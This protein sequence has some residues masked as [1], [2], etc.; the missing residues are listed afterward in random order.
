MATADQSEIARS[1]DVLAD[2][3]MPQKEDFDR[4]R[5]L[6]QDASDAMVDAGFYRLFVPEHLG[7]SSLPA[8]SAQIFERLARVQPAVRLYRCN[9]R[10]TSDF[11]DTARDIQPPEH[12]GSR[13]IRTIG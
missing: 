2:R 9:Q 11:E 6:D 3:F 1:A 10:S 7:G 12:D 4:A 13:G 5:K 8:V